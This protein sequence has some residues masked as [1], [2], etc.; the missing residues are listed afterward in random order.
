MIKDRIYAVCGVCR[1]NNKEYVIKTYK[2]FHQAK[3]FIDRYTT[4]K[5]G[6]YK[7]LHIVAYKLCEEVSDAKI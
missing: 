6:I 1:S 3:L 5:Y 4:Q 2:A 7:D